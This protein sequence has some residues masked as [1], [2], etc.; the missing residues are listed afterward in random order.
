MSTQYLD[1]LVDATP[2]VVELDLDSALMGALVNDMAMK[3]HPYGVIA[4]RYGLSDDQLVKFV[5]IPLVRQRIKARRAVWESDDNL[6][7]RNRVFYGNITLEAAP[8]LDRV[9]HDITTPPA[10]RMEAYKIAGKFAGLEV[11]PSKTSP[12][13]GQT[14]SQFNVT[15]VFSGSGKIE[16]IRTAAPTIDGAEIT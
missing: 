1:T 14:G 15:F 8:I 5:E 7:E 2:T 16:N 4:R 3:I 12:E 11:Q 6:P 10:I 13:N 9:I